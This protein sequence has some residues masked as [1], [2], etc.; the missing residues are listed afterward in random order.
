MLITSDRYNNW[1]WHHLGEES[2]IFIINSGRG[3]SGSSIC[4]NN[5]LMRLKTVTDRSILTLI[6]KELATEPLCVTD[7]S[8]GVRGPSVW[9]N[10]VVPVT[11]VDVL[12]ALASEL[13][14]LCKSR[15]GR[16]EL[17]LYC[18]CGRKATVKKKAK[19][20]HTKTYKSYKD[21]QVIQRHTS[22]IKTGKSYKDRQVKERHTSHTKTY[23][24]YKDRQV[25]QRQAS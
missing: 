8:G 11:A 4:G 21:I 1:Q 23:K 19:A 15:G 12:L 6:F 25:I 13:R 14:R 18:L 17:S 7:R 2:T 16:P 5:I 20:S 9:D 10:V 24:S 22:H 3:S